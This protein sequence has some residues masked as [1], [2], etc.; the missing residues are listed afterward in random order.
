MLGTKSSHT[1]DFG[2]AS[3]DVAAASH[4]LKS[5]T[6]ET[7]RAFGAQTANATPSTPSKLEGCAPSFS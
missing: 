5:P 4:P 1:P 6:T 3:H 2:P 7:R